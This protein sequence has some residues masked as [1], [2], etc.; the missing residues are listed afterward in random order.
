MPTVE[1]SPHNRRIYLLL[2]LDQAIECLRAALERIDEGRMVL[3]ADAATL[4]LLSNGLERFLK[5]A[6]HILHFEAHGAFRPKLRNLGHGPLLAEAE[7]LRLESPRVRDTVRAREDLNFAKTDGLLRA[8][9]DCLN[10]FAVTDRYFML[11]GAAGEPIDP[12]RNPHEMWEGVLSQ[13]AG[14][15][16]VAMDRATVAELLI[17]RI[18][19]Y[20]RCI[21]QAVCDSTTGDARSLASGMHCFFLLTDSDIETPVR[22]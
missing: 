7:I 1:L 6:V 15:N 10:A 20:L 9:L 22:R 8:L 13:V 5:V 17:G 2:E 11:D 19:R 14:G 16:R 3:R 18:Q 12:E 4:F 21:A